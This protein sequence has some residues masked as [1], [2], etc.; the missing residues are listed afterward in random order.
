MKNWSSSIH[1]VKIIT[2][3]LILHILYDMFTFQ[4]TPQMLNLTRQTLPMFAKKKKY[5]IPWFFSECPSVHFA[6]REQRI[7]RCTKIWP[8]T[9]QSYCVRTS[10]YS[11]LNSYSHFPFHSFSDRLPKIFTCDGF[12]ITVGYLFDCIDATL[13][14]PG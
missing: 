5:K 3:T 8:N 2:C 4:F 7:F 12:H 6:N 11:I 9:W 13:Q 1:I 14:H 10:H